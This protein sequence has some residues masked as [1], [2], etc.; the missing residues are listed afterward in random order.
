MKVSIIL[1][2][3]LRHDYTEQVKNHNLYN[4]GHEFNL[5]QLDIYGISKAINTGIEQSKGYDAVV[6]MA[7]DILMPDNWLKRMVE[8]A[9][10]I[11][12]T[13]M[14]GIHCVLDLLE[15]S[16]I[17]GIKVHVQIT[18]FGN[19]LI[20]MKAIEKIGKFNENLDPY[21]VQDYDY[22]YRLQMT[23]HI[24]Y[25]LYGLSSN[26]IGHDSGQN[27]EYRK[28]KDESLSKG[29]E[30]WTRESQKYID[31]NSYYL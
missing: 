4:A 17:N 19:V 6:I 22:S 1:L 25:Y 12:N 14:V 31:T 27:S 11:E 15:P 8:A 16:V 2:D 28:M 20:P 24:N 29:G 23:G 26:H 10:A 30:I 5:V 9:T 7:N 3:Y 21:S 13:G 18:P